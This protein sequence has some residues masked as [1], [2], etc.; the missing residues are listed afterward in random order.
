MASPRGAEDGNVPP[1]DV[2]IGY[3]REWFKQLRTSA[4][5]SGGSRGR[6]VL[7]FLRSLAYAPLDIMRRA[8]IPSAEPGGG[9]TS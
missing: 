2:L 6:Q 8:T 9:C 7:V 4:N 3:V 1:H 5:E